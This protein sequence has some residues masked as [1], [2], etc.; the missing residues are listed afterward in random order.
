MAEEKFIYSFVGE[1]GPAQFMARPGRG[2]EDGS[3]RHVYI[4]RKFAV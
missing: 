4:L 3:G 1:E 2:F